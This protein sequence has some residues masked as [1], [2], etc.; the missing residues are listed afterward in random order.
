MCRCAFCSG[1]QHVCNGTN[2]TFLFLAF[3][4][5][6]CKFTQL[7][8]VQLVRKSHS[9]IFIKKRF[10]WLCRARCMLFSN[11]AAGV[12]CHAVTLHNRLIMTAIIRKTNFNLQLISDYTEWIFVKLKLIVFSFVFCLFCSELCGFYLKMPLTWWL[13]FAGLADFNPTSTLWVPYKHGRSFPQRAELPFSCCNCLHQQEEP[14]YHI[15][16]TLLL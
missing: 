16:S 5:F 14:F 10:A 2:V 3:D 4:L 15:N 12:R 13:I 7:H 1:K 6:T 11:Y 9:S 8:T